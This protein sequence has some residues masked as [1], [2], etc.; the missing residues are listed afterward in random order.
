[1]S[2]TRQRQRSPISLEDLIARGYTAPYEALRWERQV[3]DA[4]T[5]RASRRVARRLVAQGLGYAAAGAAVVYVVPRI[6]V[7]LHR[8]VEIPD[9]STLLAG[10]TMPPAATLLL[11]AVWLVAIVLCIAA[12]MRLAA[13]RPRRGAGAA[14]RAPTPASAAAAAG[15][16]GS[17]AASPA[18]QRATMPPPAP[19]PPPTP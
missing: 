5:D 16:A 1:M 6:P 13:R 15:D 8:G 3:A 2:K 11:A 12:A 4:D 14:T 17:R 10:I 7:Y 18:P 9:A 19:P